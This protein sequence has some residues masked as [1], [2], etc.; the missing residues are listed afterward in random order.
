MPRFTAELKVL[1]T[2]RNLNCSSSA[3]LDSNA[4]GYTFNV[5][6]IM[7]IAMGIL[8]MA[9]GNYSGKVRSNFWVGVRTP[10]TLS[11]ENVWNKTNRLTGRMF[12]LWGTVVI[13][14]AVFRQI[15]MWLFL[16]ILG[17]CVFSV[18]Y[19]FWIWKKEKR[20]NF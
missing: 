9:M 19:S 17:I 11:S 4:F 15:S 1:S 8:F 13:L 5:T 10:W 12:V 16:G 3:N 2:N 6:G 14:S 20:Q 7:F 18:I